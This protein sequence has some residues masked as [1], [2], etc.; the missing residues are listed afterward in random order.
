MLSTCM[1]HKPEL[2][3]F[4]HKIGLLA[5]CFFAPPPLDVHNNRRLLGII[6]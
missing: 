1:I 6:F 2:W 5:F 3:R 4:L